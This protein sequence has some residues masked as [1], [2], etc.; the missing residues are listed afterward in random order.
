VKVLLVQNMTCFPENGGANKG[1]RLLL[2]KL[3]DRGHSC[4]MLALST[5]IQGYKTRPEFLRGLVR[6]GIDLVSCSPGIDIFRRGGIEVHAVI[7]SS[8][9]RSHLEKQ[10]RGFEPTWT[11]VSS[12]DTAQILLGTAL[13]ANRS[14]VVYLARTTWYLPF[15]PASFLTSR[16]KT[17]LLR[18]AAGIVAVNRY[19]Q[20]YIH[21]WAGLK[22]VFI[23]ISALTLGTGPFPYFG[24]FDQGFVTMVNPCAVKGISVFVALAQSLPDLQFAAVPSWGTTGVDLAALQKLPNIQLL[25]PVDNID[26][27]FARTRILLVPSLWAEAFA[28]IVAEAMLRGI[29]VLASNVGGLPEA[30]LGV[31]YVL[32]VRQIERYEKQVD[33]KMNPIPV[34]PGQ[35]VGPW[36]EALRE[37]IENRDRYKEVSK[38]SREAAHAAY[39]SDGVSIA[40]F[41]EFLENLVPAP[42]AELGRTQNIVRD[43]D[44]KGGSFPACVANLSPAKCAL[45]ALWSR[46]R[47]EDTVRKGRTEERSKS[48]VRFSLKDLRLFSEASHDKN[49]LHL[50]AAYTRKTAF[51]DQVVFGVLGGLACLGQTQNQDNLSLSSVA[52][53]FCEP[54]LTGIDYTVKTSQIS[55]D[56]VTTNVYDGRRIVL[57]MTANYQ[58][59]SMDAPIDPAAHVS[60]RTEPADLRRSDLVRGFAVKGEYSPSWKQVHDIIERFNLSKKGVGRSQI[61]MLMLCSYLVG[62]ELP[63]LRALFYRLSLNF[64]DFE[65]ESNPPF[66][67]EAEVVEFNKEIDLLKVNVEVLSGGVSLAKGQLESFVRRDSI[68]VDNSAINALLPQSDALKN[69]VAL[70]VGA[71]RG[72][73]A[74]IAQ[75]L[76]LQGCTVLANFLKSKAEAERLK[77]SLS[78][79]PGKI[80]LIQADGSDL[81]DCERM[82]RNISGDYGRLDFLICNASPAP[83]AMSLRPGTVCRINE[84]VGKAL[85]VVSVP[86][87]MFL[88]ILSQNSGCNIVISSLYVQNTPAEWPHYVSAKCAV[89]GLVK[90]AAVEYKAVSFLVV[91]P[92]RLLTDITN[93]PFARR[94]AIPLANVAVKIVKRLYQNM[95]PGCVE[96]LEEFSHF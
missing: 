46:K 20:E 12:E 49:P 75:T 74:A 1:N 62:M 52:L 34:V 30:K 59:K 5:S 14:Q 60:A 24:R 45:L 41:E 78:D 32:P 23:P 8:Y 29:P 53:E 42:Q 86:M 67:Y 25:K 92:P 84:Y 68:V 2:E 54:V 16:A 66:V 85:T 61:V 87:A 22:S 96:V 79:A 89:E 27:I 31:D 4:Q 13:K 56:R 36:L 72:L 51:G 50:S 38:A 37:L 15:G 18:Q 44:T 47:K 70:V 26:E 90:A 7:D 11:L 81:H 39:M 63:G 58:T 76:V 69:K 17:A 19:I 82:K 35:D 93:T 6:G 64:E 57:K 3:A 91:R 10:I 55:P 40:P 21:K 94:D 73:G 71:S 65:C 48:N 88:D 9:L 28:R 83:L 33:E 43:R 77:E 80:V 95:N